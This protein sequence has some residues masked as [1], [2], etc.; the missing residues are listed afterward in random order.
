MIDFTRDYEQVLSSTDSGL[1]CRLL[2][3]AE[4]VRLASVGD[5][6]HLRGL[7]EFSNVCQLDCYY[8]GLRKSNHAIRRYRLGLSE[9]LELSRTA[10]ELGIL[11]IALQSGEVN[12]NR[13]VDYICSVVRAIKEDSIRDGSPGLG[14][15]LSCGEL[16]YEQYL[17]LF[18][19]GAHRYLLRIESSRP[20]LFSRI[21]PPVQFYGRRLECLDM[22]KDIGYQVGTGIM[23]GLPGQT[24]E[25]LAQDLD[26]FKERNIDML[27]L[28]PYIPH[29]QTPMYNT[30]NPIIVEPYINTLKMMALTRIALPDTNM[31]VSTAL[32]TIR[33]DGLKLGVKAG[34]NV[35][36]PVLTPEEHR[37]DY[38]L[39]VNKRF[40]TLEVLKE[41]IEAAGYS[42]ALGKWGDSRHYFRRLNLPYPE[43]I[44]G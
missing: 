23:V 32:Q 16:S 34:G 25:H 6:V 28:G 11:S 35:V 27:G 36:M 24:C 4:K 12:S 29:P 8:C 41:E 44:T 9:V 39:Y 43:C 2:E 1:F 33:P 14:I 5:E 30:S 17:R 18:E 31:V 15:T 21:H 26:F 7:I 37:S 19:A 3:A 42:M 22:L 13:Q 10:R 38:A 20:D 40:K